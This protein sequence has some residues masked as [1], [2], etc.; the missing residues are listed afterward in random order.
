MKATICIITCRRP[1]GLK[2]LLEALI[3]QEISSETQLNIVVVDNACEQRTADIVN[4]IHI[5][6]PYHIHYYEEP[7]VGIVAARN[8]CVKEFLNT[9]SDYLLFIDDDEWPEES[10]WVQK[11]LEAKIKYKADIIAGNV[12]SVGEEGTPQWA[13]EL[14]YGN[15]KL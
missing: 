14:L 8:K 9:E 3:L 10:D 13:T 11:M 15:N 12:L 4:E 7:E 6:S 5:K 1:N 2:R